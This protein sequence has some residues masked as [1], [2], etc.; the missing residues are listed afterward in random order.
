MSQLNIHNTQHFKLENIDFLKSADFRKIVMEDLSSG[1]RMISL[2]PVDRKDRSKIIAVFADQSNSMITVTGCD[3]GNGPFEFESFANEFPQTNFFE[4]ELAENHGFTL[5]NHPW[6]RPVR[7]QTVINGSTPYEFFGIT[8]DE[9]HEVAVG[10][11]HAGVIEPGH[12]RFQCHG[13]LVYNLEINL[14]YQHRGIEDLIM[15][16]GDIQRIILTESIAG[17]TVM[18]HMSAHCNAIESLCSTTPGLR[19]QII[20]SIGEEI[21]RIAMH[22]GC[23]SGIANDVGFALAANSYGRIR[24]IM[25][26]SLGLICGS[27]FGRGLFNYGGVRF[28]I[29]E[30]TLKTLLANMRS[31]KS[32]IAQINAL[33]FSSVGA[34]SRFENTG[35]VSFS[36]ASSTGLVGIAARSC[37]IKTDTRVNF[38]YGAYR[39]AHLSMMT[40]QAGDV[41]ARAK[42]R[43]LEIDES[44][45][46]II[47]QLENL[48]E[49]EV[50]TK[51]GEI[52]TAKGVVSI[53]EG[54]R[55]EIVH[56][57]ITDKSGK[58]MQYKIKDP[59]FNNWYGLSLALRNTAISDF[60]LCNK[61]FDL[62]YAG[63]D[64]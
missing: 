50:S 42:I 51:M 43:S 53:S 52:A 59:S 61:S 60:P 58:L 33:M 29:D 10:P 1:K 63:H 8:G 2:C 21:E 62:S 41:F 48:P 36:D 12:F 55:G 57:A 49:G 46:Y 17:D 4:C 3:F 64:L 39:Y 15:K 28:D 38:P 24:T 30:I 35:Q 47:E 40:M 34:L 6:Q 14:G 54:F 18:G 31:V 26:N 37:D 23:L 19:A 22:I 32:D 44:F 25:I 20:R 9:I 56:I 27:R 11:I 45:R 16:A 7:K 5:L 13:E